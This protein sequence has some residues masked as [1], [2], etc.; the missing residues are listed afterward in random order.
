MFLYIIIIKS[1]IDVGG[2]PYWASSVY[3]DT[4]F[5][6]RSEARCIAFMS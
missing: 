5:G 6:Q 1:M 4:Q 2:N 3:W